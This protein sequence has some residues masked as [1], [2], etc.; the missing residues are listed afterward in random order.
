MRSGIGF[1][2]LQDSYRAGK[3]IAERALV[4][5]N[6]EVPNLVLAFCSG[7]FDA[8]EFFNGIRSMPRCRS[9][10]VIGGSAIGI[11]TNDELAY[12]DGYISGAAIIQLDDTWQRL[13]MAGNLDQN[14]YQAG[15]NLGKHL[16]HGPAGKLL[17]MF[18]ETVK[19]SP[20]LTT[21]PVMNA[22]P[23]LIAGIE[24]MLQPSIAIVGGG[25][26]GDLLFSPTRQFCGSFVGNQ[27]VVGAL[28]GGNLE[29][30]AQIMHGCV[31]KDGIYHTITRIQGSVIYEIDG[32]PIVDVINN[33][34]GDCRWQTQ[35]PLKR[36]AIG[37]NFGDKFSHYQED[38]IVTRLLLGVAQDGEGIALFEPDLEQGM[39][40]LFML[41]DGQM[42]IESARDNANALMQRIVQAGHI[43]RLALYIDC[44]GRAA[45]ISDTL[46]EEAAEIQAVMNQYNAPLL[47][48][49][50]GVEVA[51]LLGR[52]RGL[53]W[54]GVLLVLA[55]KENHAQRDDNN[56][57][58][59]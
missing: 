30:Y 16:A 4:H 46:T 12:D 45:T 58:S 38:S 3:Q 35:R 6:I 43:P 11:I 9:V 51:P 24:T 8:E 18:Y 36:L 19:T 15:R 32:Q 31:P 55:E 41:R 59:G 1:S 48:F 14:E 47:G 44:A 23:L 27:C 17:L 10:P 21:P 20:T 42:M 22:S 13:A 39:E 25:V 40:I 54:T 56:R 37:V 53:D 52:S 7:Q 33:A 34:Y 2:N 5:G 57:E 50:S 26:L 49:Y 28:F 29:P